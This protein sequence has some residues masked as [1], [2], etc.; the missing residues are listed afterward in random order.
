MFAAAVACLAVCQSSR[1]AQVDL[2]NAHLSDLLVPGSYA[3]VGNERFDTFTFSATSSGGAMQPDPTNIK[4]SAINPP[5]DTGLFFQGGP[6]LTVGNQTVDAHLTFD[7]T[8]LN[9]S[10][11]IT[12]ANLSYTAATAGG[13]SASILEVVR[14]ASNQQ[15]GQ[16]LVIEQQNL[17]NGGMSFATMTFAPQ[18]TI[19]VSKDILLVGD[20]FTTTSP[21]NVAA[22]S[23]FSQAFDGPR[24]PEP[25]SVVM[26]AMGSAGLGWFGWRRKNRNRV[27]QSLKA[28]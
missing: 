9:P 15:L 20:A 7:V 27:R 8:A 24:V 19:Q 17:P 2:T 4:V 3:I 23:D 5:P 11:P 14:D 1:A 25:S 10:L 12:M 18:T 22:V 28:A 26:A 16:Q 6:F 13:G 21:I